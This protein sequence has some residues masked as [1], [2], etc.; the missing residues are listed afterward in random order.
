ML[1]RIWILKMLYISCIVLFLISFDTIFNMW[2]KK[3]CQ[4]IVVVK[5]F[6]LIINVIY[7]KNNEQIFVIFQLNYANVSAV[8]L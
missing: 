8:L 5:F 7:C 1:R 6:M 3:I 4:Y 2:D